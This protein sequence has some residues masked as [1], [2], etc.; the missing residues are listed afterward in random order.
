MNKK[1]FEKIQVLIQ[2]C[3]Q[4][5]AKDFTEIISSE[6]WEKDWMAIDRDQLV[7]ILKSNELVVPS[8]TLLPPP[9][10]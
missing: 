6:D 2:N 9:N 10:F 1:I 4:I 8:I 3:I 5:L 7:E